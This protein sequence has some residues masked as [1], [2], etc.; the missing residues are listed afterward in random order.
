MAGS[1]KTEGGGGVEKSEDYVDRGWAWMVALGFFFTGFCTIG[2]V[3]SF[4]ILIQEIVAYF[5]VPLYQGVMIM[6]MQAIGFTFCAPILIGLGEKYSQRTV[7]I[8]SAL[9]G[10]VGIAASSFLF[11]LSFVIVVGVLIGIG[12]SGIFPNGL[13]IISKYFRR[14]LALANGLSMSGSSIGVLGLPPII[15]YLLNNYGLKGTLLL[16]SGIYLQCVV[17]GALYRPPSFY[18]RRKRKVTSKED[19]DEMVPLTEGH[20]NEISKAD[21]QNGLI[22]QNRSSNDHVQPSLYK[23]S[24]TGSLNLGSSW[25]SYSELNSEKQLKDDHT[26]KNRTCRGC[27]KTF[28][29]LKDPIVKFYCIYSFF[30]FL[31]FFNFILFM[32]GDAISKGIEAYDKALLVSFAGIGD[33]L[34]RLSV[35]GVG[36]R[37]PFARYKF[38]AL[39]CL[40]NGINVLI[41][42]FATK[43]WWMGLHS[44]LYGYLGGIFVALNSVVMIDFLGV[45]VLPK[46]LSLVMVSQGIAVV[47]GQPFLG[48]LK[49]VSGSFLLPNFIMGISML[50]SGIFLFLYPLVKRYVEKKGQVVSTG[51]EEFI[52]AEKKIEEL[53]D[54]DI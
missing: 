20:K 25:L 43:F 28:S 24:S 36:D 19:T 47:L 23:M 45:K 42:G 37:L 50:L 46:A 39:S 48:Y 31:G 3:K 6:S 15:Q 27:R 41:Y 5:D 26:P 54:D 9:T 30:I 49:D 44:T 33:L 4:G 8:L 22:Q 29:L 32:P 18:T 53:E 14:H 2:I 13:V 11:S 38:N 17:C 34:G 16:V 52:I 1:V 12:N 40:L 7:V 10:F 35:A 51:C 21:E